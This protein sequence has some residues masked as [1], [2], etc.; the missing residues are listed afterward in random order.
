M[1]KFSTISVYGCALKHMNYA[2]QL[3]HKRELLKETLHKY[4][5]HL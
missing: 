1:L 3:V 5:I 4:K 2:D